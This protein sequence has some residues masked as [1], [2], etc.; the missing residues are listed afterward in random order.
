MKKLFALIAVFG[1]LSFGA[2][3]FSIAAQVEATDSTVTQ[4]ATNGDSTAVA[5]T[6]SSQAT[7]EVV[8]KT[9]EKT[10][11]ADAAEVETPGLHQQIKQKFIEGG[12]GFMSFVLL[13][14][15]LGLALA[16]ERIIYLNLASTNTEKL[17]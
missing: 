11:D 9:E 4:E 15:I 8:A 14:L 17:L 10:D 16:I 2:S 7:E 3:N 6:D 13:A 12:P 1:M 5:A